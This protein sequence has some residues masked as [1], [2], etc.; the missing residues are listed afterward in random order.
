MGWHRADD[1][2]WQETAEVIPTPW[3]RGSA[4][5]DMRW[6]G[7]RKQHTGEWIPGRR[8][9][10]KRWGWTERKART[11]AIVRQHAIRPAAAQTPASDNSATL[12]RTGR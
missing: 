8:F 6:Y 7:D 12:P 1:T 3:P 11:L 2:W 4:L 5:H 9:F 10:A